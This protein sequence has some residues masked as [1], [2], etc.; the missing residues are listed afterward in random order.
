MDNPINIKH[1]VIVEQE[2]VDKL[3]DIVAIPAKAVYP[4]TTSQTNAMDQAKIDFDTMLN[5]YIH[6]AFKAGKK[7]GKMY[8]KVNQDLLHYESYLFINDTN[9]IM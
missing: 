3:F 8:P 9:S 5:L 4:D 7:V 2:A 6:K 1:V